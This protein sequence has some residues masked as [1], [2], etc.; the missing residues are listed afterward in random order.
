[1]YVE[2]ANNYFGD[3]RC[4]ATIKFEIALEIGRSLKLRQM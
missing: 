1:M 3:F 2:N 4:S